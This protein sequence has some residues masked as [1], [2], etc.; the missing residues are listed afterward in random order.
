MRL[1][2]IYLPLWQASHLRPPWTRCSPRLNAD[3]R[4]DALVI[5]RGQAT[6]IVLRSAAT[7][8]GNWPL[9]GIACREDS[10]GAPQHPTSP[11]SGHGSG[12]SASGQRGDGLE[13]AQNRRSALSP[14]STDYGHETVDAET[15]SLCD[16]T[17]AFGDPSC[18]ITV[19]HFWLDGGSWKDP[20]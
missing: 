13:L 4:Q 19:A 14:E 7:F 11:L 6:A 10:K 20:A 3:D 12:H 16:P 1:V 17:M 8:S 9:A 5:C 18:K 15:Q 2:P